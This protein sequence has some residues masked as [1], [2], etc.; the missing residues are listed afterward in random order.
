LGGMIAINVYHQLL[1]IFSHSFNGFNDFYE[2]NNKGGAPW[3]AFFGLKIKSNWK[4]FK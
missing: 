4:I 1:I 2:N 3:S